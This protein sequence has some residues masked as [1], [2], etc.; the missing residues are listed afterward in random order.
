MMKE[1]VEKIVKM[2]EPNYLDFEGTKYTDKNV[3]PVEEPRVKTLQFGTLDGMMMTLF[4]EI[5]MF[6]GPVVVKASEHDRVDVMSAVHGNNRIRETPY[7]VV[8]DKPNIE[9]ERFVESEKMIIQ[10]KSKFVETPELNEVVQLLGTIVSEES[11]K[12][13]DDGFT[14]QV[15]VRSG[16]VT[17]GNKM[18]NPI[19]TLSPYR[20]FTEVEQPASQFLIRLKNT[21]KGAHAAIFEAD[22]GAWKVQARKN[23]AEYLRTGLAIMVS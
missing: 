17:R 13:C 1:F 20:T 7:I 10:L 21:D 2:A 9:F 16:V 8:A 6:A 19:V 23:V 11:E 18:V 15:V 3:I 5:D 12:T 22:G 14:Q 4:R